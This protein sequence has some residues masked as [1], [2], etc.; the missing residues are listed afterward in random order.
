M[1]LA[2]YYGIPSG[3]HP[4]IC[5]TGCPSTLC[6]RIT[7]TVVI[8]SYWNLVDRWTIWWYSTLCFAVTVYQILIELLHFL[9]IFLTTLFL[10]NSSYSFVF[11]QLWTVRLWDDAGHIVSRLQYSYCSLKIV[12]A[13]FHFQLTSPLIKLLFVCCWIERR[14]EESQPG[15]SIPN[16]HI[17]SRLQYTKFSLSYYLLKHPHLLSG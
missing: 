4:S 10:D 1:I 3:V 2:G 13:W 17:L 6:F 12:Q 5:L 11:I 15:Y 7:P 16:L 8:W 9:T 14:C